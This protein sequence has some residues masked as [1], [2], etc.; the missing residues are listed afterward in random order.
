MK[1]RSLHRLE[2]QINGRIVAAATFVLHE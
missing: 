2:V 1:P